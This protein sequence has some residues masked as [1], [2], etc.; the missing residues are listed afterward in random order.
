MAVL[1]VG[2]WAC[3][4]G[5]EMAGGDE[6]A[7]P[8][9]GVVAA[10]LTSLATY[11]A[12]LKVPRCVSVSSGC[13]SGTLVDGRG[14]VGPEANAPNTLGGTCADSTHGVYHSDE[15]VDRVKV[16]TN[17]GSKLAPGKQVTIEVNVWAYAAYASDAL[18]LYY[19]ADANSPT[20]TYLTTIVPAGPGAQTIQASYTLPSGGGIQAVR[21]AFRYQG[22]A[23]PCTTGYYDDRD[24]LAFAVEKRRQVVAGQDH[25]LL[26]REDGTV[27]AWGINTYGQLGDG[28]TTSRTTP[29]RVVGLDNVAY[30][31]A[32]MWHS[33]ALKIDGTVWAWGYNGQRQLGDG[34]FTNRSLPVQVLGLTGVVAIAAGDTHSLALM[35][36]GSLRAWGSNSRGELGDGTFAYRSTSV[37]VSGLTGVVAIAAG[38]NHSLAVK[39]DGTVWAWGMNDTAQ[40]GDGTYTD[41]ST[42]VQVSG[43]TGVVTVA[44]GASHSLALKRDGTVW[45]WGRGGVGQLGDGTFAWADR[46][47]PVQASGLSGVTAISSG[48]H[49]GLAVR[50][51]GSLW[52]W[53][54]NGYGRLGDGTTTNRAS[55]VQVL[56][57]S[58]VV[59]ISGGWQHSLALTQDGSSWAWG[60]NSNGQLGDGT[61]T[62]HYSPVRVLQ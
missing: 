32:G 27:W 61:Y 53:G 6:S 8:E 45:G 46:L 11:D 28:T 48:G 43:L 40:L 34:T 23:S 17:D 24:D 50:S 41:R 26:L 60:G 38:A 62:T 20:W 2:L 12:T 42:P 36:D 16:Y 56:G 49:H 7:T 58:G 44:G 13:D 31:A 39:Q 30:L 22:S 10:P 5:E 37:Q 54:A 35:G 15:S 59:S 18:D 3:G 21:A 14:P 57:L 9:L 1:A 51:D 25:S 52:T 19:A 29:V 33:L 4:P 55:P 47:T